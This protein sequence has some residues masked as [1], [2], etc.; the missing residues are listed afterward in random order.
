MPE[1]IFAKRKRLSAKQKK[2]GRP[3]TGIRPMIGL[4]LSKADIARV[5]RWA[6]QHDVTRS[7]AIRTLIAESLKRKS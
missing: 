4:R 7:D 3:A 6:L 5:D 1:S 2:R